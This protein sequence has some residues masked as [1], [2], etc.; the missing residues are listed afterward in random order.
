MGN[1]DDAAE[2]LKESLFGPPRPYSSFDI[3]MLLGRVYDRCSEEEEG[4]QGDV[5]K[6][7]VSEL[8][9][10]MRARNRYMQAYKISHGIEDMDDVDRR[11]VARWLGKFETWQA[12]AEKCIDAGHFVY[13]VDAYQQALERGQE[14]KQ[15]PKLWYELAKA[16]F[17]SGNPPDAMVALKHANELIHDLNMK[18]AQIESTIE[19]WRL[20]EKE[21]ERIQKEGALTLATILEKVGGYVRKKEAKE[22]ENAKAREDKQSTVQRRLSGR[23]NAAVEKVREGGDARRGEARRG[24]A[25]RSRGKMFTS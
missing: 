14:A 19:N 23:D 20:R 4:F 22:N 18:D 25:R 24:D 11:E 12:L 5:V 13:A 9:M 16:L 3:C 8:N 2:F 1:N 17:R 10:A 21:K 6:Q 15:N 7:E